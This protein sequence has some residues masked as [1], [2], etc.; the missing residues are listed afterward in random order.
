[1]HHVLP[2]DLPS[3]RFEGSSDANLS[4]SLNFAKMISGITCLIS[5]VSALDN[6]DKVILNLVVDFASPLPVIVRNRENGQ[7]G[8]VFSEASHVYDN[9]SSYLGI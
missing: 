8:P 9:F 6:C 3:S 2:L 7:D 1:V 5:Q 4:R